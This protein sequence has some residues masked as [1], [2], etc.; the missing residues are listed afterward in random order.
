MNHD[1][2]VYVGTEPA[3]LYRSNNGGESWD[4]HQ[5]QQMTQVQSQQQNM[6]P[7]FNINIH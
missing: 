2:T 1:N 6:N 4:S 7:T 3:A 5:Q